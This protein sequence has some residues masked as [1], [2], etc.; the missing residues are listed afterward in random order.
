MAVTSRTDFFL[1]L[2][3]FLRQSARPL[4][5]NYVAQS[6]VLSVSNISYH[7]N[8][9][10]SQFCQT[11]KSIKSIKIIGIWYLNWNEEK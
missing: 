4:L 7:V 11:S 2:P 6:P 5:R 1:K 9:T 10:F 3:S 8:L